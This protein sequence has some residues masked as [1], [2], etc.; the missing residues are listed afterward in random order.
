MPTSLS[1]NETID[2]A[3]EVGRQVDIIS[4]ALANDSKFQYLSD[5]GVSNDAVA[6]SVKELGDKVIRDKP[7][8]SKHELINVLHETVK[9]S[10][11]EQ[12]SDAF[13]P[14]YGS[15]PRPKTEEV[16]AY[17]HA[18]KYQEGLMRESLSKNSAD[19]IYYADDRA[20]RSTL[21][22]LSD[23]YADY[24]VDTLQAYSK[25]LQQ[26]IYRDINA[27]KEW[28]DQDF[29]SVLD[30][31]RDSAAEFADALDRVG[32]P[33]YHLSINLFPDSIA[34]EAQ[35]EYQRDGVEDLMYYVKGTQV[36]HDVQINF[37]TLE[38]GLNEVEEDLSNRLP[39]ADYHTSTNY[40]HNALSTL[41]DEQMQ[42]PMYA[43]DREDYALDIKAGLQEVAIS[44]YE[45][46]KPMFGKTDHEFTL[47]NPIYNP[48]DSGAL[49]NHLSKG[50]Y[51]QVAGAIASYPHGSQQ[52][53]GKMLNSLNY[54][55]P[56]FH[57]SGL[58]AAIEQSLEE[59]DKVTNTNYALGK[60]NSGIKF[61]DALKQAKPLENTIP[62]ANYSPA[63]TP[64][65]D[66]KPSTDELMSPIGNLRDMSLR[67]ISQN[68]FRP[69][70]L[71][72]MLYSFSKA[73]YTKPELNSV[74][75]TPD[76]AEKTLM[77]F[78][79]GGANELPEKLLPS[80][81]D[82]IML[83]QLERAA[84]N[85]EMAAI[86]NQG[87]ERAGNSIDANKFVNDVGLGKRP[88][89]RFFDEVA[90]MYMGRDYI[91]LGNL[92]SRDRTVNPHPIDSR[93]TEKEHLA[94]IV[95]MKDTLTAGER[96]SALSMLDNKSHNATDLNGTINT[97]LAGVKQIE[98]FMQDFGDKD[99]RS[100]STENFTQAT[101]SNRLQLSKGEL[102]EAA[103][104]IKFEALNR[105]AFYSVNSDLSAVQ[106]LSKEGISEH[107]K[108]R[109]NGITKTYEQLLTDLRSI[110]PDITPNIRTNQV[111]DN[112]NQL[113]DDMTNFS[114][115]VDSTIDIKQDIKT[116]L[117]YS[118]ASTE[119]SKML[120]DVEQAVSDKG[121][122]DPNRDIAVD[123]TNMQASRDLLS[124][125][126]D[127]IHAMAMHKQGI[128]LPREPQPD[129]PATNRPI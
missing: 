38:E 79:K 99:Y 73:V 82:N 88:L 15:N 74:A 42:S 126:V 62:K 46:L 1:Q 60:A 35:N 118:D 76:D 114:K 66:I 113:V 119:I 26:K 125:N 21:S 3:V 41:I 103:R 24:I 6:N 11:D 117:A 5:I 7:V 34:A 4:N 95:S 127:D 13:L 54:N 75:F 108:D 84:Q 18:S 121:L 86:T 124:K 9:Q 109:F 120:N 69:D 19:D 43:Q 55:E 98:R 20:T 101:Q 78:V 12:L 63:S 23:R 22:G 16:F 28:V 70:Y 81:R 110:S 83:D 57:K 104:D 29:N 33:S 71:V 31:A 32:M 56:Y 112:V 105:S 27:K 49:P 116:L 58:V 45:N 100:Q 128:N 97:V 48:L 96:Q 102:R 106:Q 40:L 10:F 53:I 80:I 115:S 123:V 85:K 72:D 65:E 30:T 50:D 64:K 129:S 111:V 17:H 77:S 68:S 25:P 67:E 36:F 107:T 122:D 93:L 94:V 47:I 51:E 2:H 8:L 59:F 37:S 87:I 89:G 44:H 92:N 39:S 14:M 52:H 90:E 61:E 91:S